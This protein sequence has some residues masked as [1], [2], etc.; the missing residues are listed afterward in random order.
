M[1]LIESSYGASAVKLMKIMRQ[2]DRHDVK[3]ISVD[4][5]LAGKL[6]SSYT[7]GDTSEM[8]SEALIAEDVYAVAA[9]ESIQ[10]IEELA[11]SLGDRMLERSPRILNAKVLVTERLWDHMPV[12][13][14][15]SRFTFVRR[16]DIK[17]TCYVITTEDGA[18]VESGIDDL[19]VL[20]S[21]TS[22][23]AARHGVA[24]MA[25]TARWHYSSTDISY[26]PSWN[27]VRKM[28][29]ETV[30]E[31]E[32]RSGQYTLYAIGEMVLNEIADIDEIRLSMRDWE[33][34][35]LTGEASTLSSNEI[36]RL[37]HE[38]VGA[39]EAVLRR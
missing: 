8:P 21:P 27:G 14:G 10:T 15:E 22:S 23:K 5:Q 38:P 39:T 31:H 26:G 11:L 30:A 16:D 29:L 28:I 33:Y 36:L 18:S 24:A 13:S 6:E 7:Q 20:K 2:R 25:I 37:I 12:E 3:E 4:V 17:H 32:A 34:A 1:K 35:P 9:E 19:I